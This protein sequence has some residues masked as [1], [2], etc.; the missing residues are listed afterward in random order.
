MIEEVAPV[1]PLADAGV[2]ETLEKALAAAKAGDV[3]AVAVAIVGRDNSN[4]AEFCAGQAPVAALMGSIERM[5]HKLNL[6]FDD[7]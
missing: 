1:V 7:C 6:H 3:G 2:V 5:R 4:W